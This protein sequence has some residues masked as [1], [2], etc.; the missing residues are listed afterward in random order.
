MK[1]TLTDSIRRSSGRLLRN[2]LL[3]R[4]HLP[5]T[6][7]YLLSSIFHLPSHAAL[8]LPDHVVYGTIAFGVRPVTSTDTDV[9]IEAR[10]S[11]NGP[12]LASYRMGQTPRLGGHY[13]ELRLALED[14][15]S[16]PRAAAVGETLLVI[17]RSARGIQHQALHVI[18]DAGTAQRLDFGV[19]LDTDGDGV[20]DGWEL[21]AL[22]THGGDLRRD[23]DGDAAS[24]AA[25]YAAGTRPMDAADVFRLAVVRDGDGLAV[26]LRTLAAAGA[27][28]EGR[29]RYYALESTADPA[30]GP[31]QPVENHSRIQGANQLVVYR[32]A[33]GTNPPAFFRA[34]V[35]LEGP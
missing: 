28:Y 4:L 13:Y 9:V 11:L 25:E 26:S 16:S 20:P 22:G 19:T 10:R 23:T 1:T 15:V 17:V 34:R 14:E 7:F 8:P 12:V 27:G 24:D 30:A 31:W 6:I 3:R 2:G 33:G 5:S 35:W 32:H 29:R 21:A 18:S